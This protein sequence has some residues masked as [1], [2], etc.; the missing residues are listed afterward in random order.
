MTA[1]LEIK[2]QKPGPFALEFKP[3][4]DSYVIDDDYIIVITH[5]ALE[6]DVKVPLLCGLITKHDWSQV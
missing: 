1:D 6:E 2:G 5:P 3:D 4:S